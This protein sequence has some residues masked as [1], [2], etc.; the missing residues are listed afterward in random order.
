M[1]RQSVGMTTIRKN[2]LVKV[3]RG[4]IYF[5]PFGLSATDKRRFSDRLVYLTQ[6]DCNVLE[7]LLENGFIETQDRLQTAGVIMYLTDKGRNA[8]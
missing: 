4:K 5:Y 1:D 6:R 7:W 8:L 2:Q 3:G